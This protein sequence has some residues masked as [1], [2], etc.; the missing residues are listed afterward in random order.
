MIEQ[1][2]FKVKVDGKPKTIDTVVDTDPTSSRNPI[3]EGA[4]PDVNETIF[5]PRVKNRF[6]VKLLD[7][8]QNE[9]I[10]SYLI[11]EIQR[12]EI[13]M[14]EFASFPQ[15]SS[16]SISIYDPVAISL[17]KTL[18]PEVG[19]KLNISLQILGPTS[20]TI[21]TWYFENVVLTT[22]QYSNFNWSNDDLSYITAYFN[23][24]HT[25]ITIS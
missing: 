6:L 1:K 20:D 5:E 9:I 15:Y 19:K 24:N 11:K 25:T 23:T 18:N 7:Q 4:D 17:A 2:S 8:N 13:Y 3:S 14:N 12:P 21:E 10:P 22:L 16:M